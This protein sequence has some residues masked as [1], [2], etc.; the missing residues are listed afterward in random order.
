MGQGVKINGGG[1][2][3]E[4]L[5][6]EIF[7]FYKTYHKIS[8]ARFKKEM[9]QFIMFFVPLAEGGW[10]GW[11]WVCYLKNHQYFEEHIPVQI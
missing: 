3:R 4:N 6:F 9:N 7:I 10:G 1:G 2:G 11:W 8:L 5:K